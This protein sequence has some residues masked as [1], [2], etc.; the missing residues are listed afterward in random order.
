MRSVVEEALS[1]RPG[2]R[3]KERDGFGGLRGGNELALAATPGFFFFSAWMDSAS[4]TGRAPQQ[5]WIFVRELGVIYPIW[6]SGLLLDFD[7]FCFRF[8]FSFNTLSSTFVSFPH[9]LLA[10]YF[11]CLCLFLN[12]VSLVALLHDTAG[13]DLRGGKGREGGLLRRSQGK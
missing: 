12:C 3:E 11:H 9:F 1:D 5:G 7:F 2:E 6:A 10:H 4:W 8:F 13:F